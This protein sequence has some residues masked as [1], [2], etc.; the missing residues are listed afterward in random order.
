[1]VNNKVLLK[2]NQHLD[3]TLSWLTRSFN[4]DGGS[5]AY[6]S[7]IFGWSSPYPETTGY[8]IT[9]LINAFS[10]TGKEQYKIL[11]FNAGRWLQSLQNK[12]GSFP[13]GL[14]HKKQHNL[15]H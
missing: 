12:N 4:K 11:A 3:T 1:M 13:G 15:L 2:Y 9:T 10:R 6:Y 8:I 7:P 14:H 5:S